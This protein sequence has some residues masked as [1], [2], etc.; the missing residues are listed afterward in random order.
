MRWLFAL[1]LIWPIG[2]YAQDLPA[3]FNVVDVTAPDVLNIRQGPDA[4]TPK[5]G[6][7]SHDAINIEVVALS[8]AQKWG[9]VN[10]AERSGWVAMR[11]LAPVPIPTDDPLPR[12]LNCFGTEP[13][14]SI[15]MPFS[16]PVLMTMQGENPV[17]LE[18]ESYAT[19][20]GRN[21]KAGFLAASIDVGIAGAVTRTQCSDGMSDRS[22]GLAIDLLVFPNIGNGTLLSGCCSLSR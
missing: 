6:S 5:I 18:L 4:A 12:P 17:E 15:E 7:L 20:V 2:A 22:F 10:T 9:R 8:D 1:C 14:W 11:F 19:G 3:L 13:F 21:D 16:G